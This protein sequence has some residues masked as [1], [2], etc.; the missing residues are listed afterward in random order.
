[1]NGEP[2]AIH[3][4]G[5]VA[6]KIKKLGVKNTYNK[7]KGVICIAYNNKE[8]GFSIPYGIKLHFVLFKELSKLS[9]VKWGKTGAAGN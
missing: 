3:I 6:K 2:S 7:V 8:C 5:F 1:M 4:V 9:D